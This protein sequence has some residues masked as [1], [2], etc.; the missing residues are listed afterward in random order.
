MFFDYL[1]TRLERRQ[2][3]GQEHDINWRFTDSRQQFVLTLS[4]SALTWV[5]GR[6]AAGADA[7]LTL[8]RPMLDAL[9]LRRTSWSEAVKAGVSR[10]R[11]TPPS[12]KNCSP[13]STPST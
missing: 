11:A 2:G 8:P 5:Q 1:G 12:P 13:C 6:L 3:R 7:T 4:N 9:A 10:S